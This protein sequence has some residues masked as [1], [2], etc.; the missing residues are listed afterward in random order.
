M[1]LLNQRKYAFDTFCDPSPA[2]ILVCPNF[3]ENTLYVGRELSINNMRTECMLDSW[4]QVSWLWDT[5]LM[6]VCDEILP[7]PSY[8]S[9]NCLT[10]TLKHAWANILCSSYT[11]TYKYPPLLLLLIFFCFKEK[12]TSSSHFRANNTTVK[13]VAKQPTFTAQMGWIVY[14]HMWIKLTH[15]FFKKDIYEVFEIFLLS[16]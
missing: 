7:Q 12:S 2:Y 14:I 15:S 5:L 8:L 3:L 6:M 9:K 4:N 1:K 10:L 11:K 13:A 16:F